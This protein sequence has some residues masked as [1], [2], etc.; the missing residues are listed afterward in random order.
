MLIIFLRHF[1]FQII[2]PKTTKDKSNKTRTNKSKLKIINHLDD[3]KLTFLNK[4]IAHRKKK[5]KKCS[6]K[7]FI[8]FL[9]YSL[10]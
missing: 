10:D 7:I 5:T 1:V 4:K 3:G 6:T 8:Y 9:N 2:E